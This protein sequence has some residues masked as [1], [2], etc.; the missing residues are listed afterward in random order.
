MT[1]HAAGHPENEGFFAK[2]REFFEGA[3]RGD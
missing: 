1:G 2:V 3:T